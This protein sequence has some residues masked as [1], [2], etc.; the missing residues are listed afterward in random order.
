MGR[1]MV[2]TIGA[3]LMAWCAL[4][5]RPVAAQQIYPRPYD[6]I[7]AGVDSY[8]LAEEQR[9]AKLG[10]QLY[11]NDAFGYRSFA[12]GGPGVTTFY[13]VP[14]AVVTPG[15]GV[16]TYSTQTYGGPFGV[17]VGTYSSTTSFY[18]PGGYY[19][20]GGYYGATVGPMYAYPDSP[21]VYGGYIYPTAPLVRQPIGRREVQTGPNR[22][23]SHPVYDPPLPDYPVPYAPTS[24]ITP[25]VVVSPQVSPSDRVIR[26]EPRVTRPGEPRPIESR[27]AIV[28][29]VLRR[30]F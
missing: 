3:G 10:A 20:P 17:G 9:R 13:R 30:E 16:Q 4:T 24:P 19:S 27:P 6:G 7:Q 8:R 5:A 11:L 1:F 22:W 25:P 14:A 2:A 12:P 15:F 26:S 21:A 18:G 28:P 29:R 23:E